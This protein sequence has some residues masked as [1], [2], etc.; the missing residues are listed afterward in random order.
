MMSAQIDILVKMYGLD[1]AAPFELV[2]NG[3]TQN[4]QCLIRGYGA[5]S[6]MVIDKT[7]SKIFA[8]MPELSKLGYGYSCFDIEA[9]NDPA[10]FAAVLKD[11]GIMHT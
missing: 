2:V 5:P 11:W 1:V 8:V 3:K 10:G 6:G 9:S 7:W 4:F